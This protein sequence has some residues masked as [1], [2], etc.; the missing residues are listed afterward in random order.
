ML[1]LCAVPGSVLLKRNADRRRNVFPCRPHIL[2]PTP[3]ASQSTAAA[4]NASDTTI[5]SIAACM[6][7]ASRATADT[8][9]GPR[10]SVAT[11]AASRPTESAD[12][13]TGGMC[14]I[15]GVC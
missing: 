10:P 13:A 1:R 6:P 9:L 12:V 14:T 11:L 5:T 4:A 8:T 7:D 3:T 2:Y 15:C